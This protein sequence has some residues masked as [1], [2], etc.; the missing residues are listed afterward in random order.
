MRLVLR[1]MFLV[2]ARRP[3]RRRR[4]GDLRRG[5]YV[6][7]QLF[8]VA[9]LDPVVFAVST[10]ALLAASLAAALVPAWRAA[11]IDPIRALRME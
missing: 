2:F 8:G 11:R 9:Q 7:S 1:E 4:R 10:V 5:R 6:Q 3:G